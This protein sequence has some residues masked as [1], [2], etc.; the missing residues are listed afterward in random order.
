MCISS[1]GKIGS[2]IHEGLNSAGSVT[3][4]IAS[5]ISY[6]CFAL[7]IWDKKNKN[8]MQ[9]RF[10]QSYFSCQTAKFLWSG[11]NS[12]NRKQMK[13]WN[14]CSVFILLLA[15]LMRSCSD[16]VNIQTRFQLS[17]SGPVGSRAAFC[18]NEY[19]FGSTYLSKAP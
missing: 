6:F 2:L 15:N 8:Q 16:Y 9:W 14:C 10:L 18:G 19:I 3:H 7:S 12:G 5:F 17:R 4:S 13:S 1:S 11:R